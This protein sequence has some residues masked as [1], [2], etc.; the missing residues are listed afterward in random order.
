MEPFNNH[1]FPTKN[2]INQPRT[3][4]IN[5]PIEIKRNMKFLKTILVLSII[6]VFTPFLATSQG[7]IDG[8]VS[9]FGSS[10]TVLCLEEGNPGVVRFRSQPLAMPYAYLVVTDQNLI[11]HIGTSNFIDFTNMPSGIL[12]VISFSFLGPILAEVGDNYL[13]TDL[14][15]LCYQLVSNEI[16]ISNVEP[17]GGDV[18]TADGQTAIAI[19]L[20][21][22]SDN[23]INVV[24]NSDFASYTYI[25]TDE[26]N[27]ILDVSETGAVDFSGAGIGVCHVWGLAYV[28]TLNAPLGADLLD[29]ELAGGCFELS[30]NF[31]EVTRL[32]PDAGSLA[33]GDGSDSFVSCSDLEPSGNLVLTSTHNDATNFTFVMVN[34]EDNRVVALFTDPNIDLAT[35]ISGSYQ[36]YG[37]AYTGTLLIQEGGTFNIDALSDE[38]QDVSG[39][40]VLIKRVQ[41]ADNINLEDGS[42]DVTVCVGDGE[43]DEL[44]FVSTY[45]GN[46]DFV[47]LITDESNFLIGISESATI[48]FDTAEPGVC[49][50]WGLVYSGNLT[51]NVGDNIG[52]P[53]LLSDECF[54]LSDG[55]VRVD[56]NGPVAGLISYED[57]SDS[58]IS[59]TE[60][61][62]TTSLNVNVVGNDPNSDY[63]F[64]VVHS[65][66]IV[67]LITEDAIDLAILPDGTYSVFGVSYIGDLGLEPGDMFLISSITATCFDITTTPLELVKRVQHADDVTLEDGS[68]SAT[69]CV[70]DGIADELTFVSNYVGND[71]FVYLITDESNFLIGTSET[72]VID[73]EGAEAGICRIWGLVYSGDLTVA[74]GENIG[75][76]AILSTECFDLSDGFSLVDRNGPQAGSI[77][78]ADGSNSFF[79]C[80]ETL[81]TGTLTINVTG[82]DGSSDYTFV[83]VD[84]TNTIVSLNDGSIDIADLENGNY[85]IYGIAF[86]GDLGMMVGDTFDPNTSAACLVITT[87]SLQLVRRVQ[88]AGGVTLEDGSNEATVCIADGVSDELT[89]L[90]DFDGEDEFIFIITDE[91]NLVIGTSTTGV[92]EFE[93]ADPGVCHLWGLAYSGNL[94]FENGDD[95]TTGQALSDECYDL[96]DGFVT[97]NRLHPDGGTISLTNGDNSYFECNASESNVILEFVTENVEP[98]LDY[99]F[100]V[101]NTTTN[102]IVAI[103]NA[104]ILDLNSLGFGSFKVHGISYLGNLTI[105]VGDLFEGQPLSD[106]CSDLSDN[107]VNITNRAINVDHIQIVGGATSTTICPADGNPDIIFFESDY[108]GSENLVYIVTD[109]DNVVINVLAAPSDDFDTGGEGVVRVWAVTFS[110]NFILTAGNTLNE[111]LIISDECFDISDNFVLIGRN[112]PE[113]GSVALENGAT[114]IDICVGDGIAD[115]LSVSTTGLGTSYAYLITDENNNI[116]EISEDAV[117]DFENAAGGVC[118]IWVVSYTGELIAMQGDNVETTLLVTGCSELS[119]NFITVNRT[120][121]D[122]GT[123]SLEDGSIS[124]FA[125]GGDGEADFFVFS[126]EN[127]AADINYGYIITDDEE[128]VLAFLEGNS[129]DL[130]LAAAGECHV[131]GVSYTG[132]FLAAVGENINEVS[133]SEGCAEL[134][135]NFV[136]IQ[137]EQVLGGAISLSDGNTFVNI[138]P[139]D[140]NPDILSFI[141]T[142]NSTSNYTYILTD[143]NNNILSTL[144]DEFDFNNIIAPSEVRIWGLAYSGLLSELVGD[145]HEIELSNRCYNVS[146]NFIT[147]VREVPEAGTITGNGLVD[148][149]LCNDD[150]IEDL[151]TFEASGASN[152]SYAYVIAA[153]DNT[154]FAIISNTNSFQFEGLEDDLFRIWGVAYTGTLNDILF[155]DIEDVVLSNDC[156]DLSDNFITIITGELN[157]GNIETNLGTTEQFTCPGDGMA[158]IV[159]VINHNPGSTDDYAFALV[160]EDSLIV[161]LIPSG[162]IDFEAQAEGVYQIWGFIY[163]GDLLDNI[164]DSNIVRVTLSTGCFDLSDNF[165]TVTNIA[166]VAGTISVAGVTEVAVCIGDGIPDVLEFNV[167]GASGAA[168]AYMIIEADSFLVGTLIDPTLDLENSEEG[169]WRICGISY[170]GSLNALPGTNI[171]TDPLSSGCWELTTDCIF[172]DKTHVDGGEVF[173]DL[174]NQ[175]VYSCPNGASDLI[176][177]FNTGSSTEADYVYVLTTQS[178]ILLSVLTDDNIDLLDA[179]GFSNLRLWGVSYTG[180]FLGAIGNNITEVALSDG[181]FSLSSSSVDVFIDNP[182]GGVL[183]LPNGETSTTLCHSNSMPGVVT[184][185]TSSSDAGYAY[186]LTN[187]VNELIEFNLSSDGFVTFDN[188]APG[189]YRV[190]GLSYTGD[191]LLGAGSDIMAGDLATSCFELSENF[192]TIVRTESMDAGNIFTANSTSDILYLCPGDENPDLVI[193]SN[194]SDEASFRYLITDGNDD[195]FVADVEGNI[196]DFNVAPV[197]IYHIYG[198]AFD[199]DFEVDFMENVLTGTLSSQ[200]WALTNNFITIINQ[201]P[202]GGMVSIEGGATEINLTVG[203]GIA[204]EVTFVHTGLQE[205]LYSYIVTDEENVIIAISSSATIDFEAASPGTCR[206]WGVAYTGNILAMMGEDIDEISLGDDCNDLSDNFVTVVRTSTEDLE[207]DDEQWLAGLEMPQIQL[208]LSPN[209]VSNLLSIDISVPGSGA[210]DNQVLEVYNMNGLLVSSA[211]L[212]PITGEQ[213]SILDVS[214]LENGMYLLRWFDGEHVIITRFVKQ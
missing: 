116:L 203:D 200:C 114:S 209:P 142:G 158:D 177:L 121:V 117:I 87:E 27:I 52:E 43:P 54:D 50:V 187:E 124:S 58:F 32:F 190:W 37:L 108:S 71:Q 106:V 123:V 4:A 140:E 120:F 111:D 79:S 189:S 1:N 165:V 56:R 96:T 47:Y 110:G 192:V 16:V 188:V 26:N 5:F 175:V 2:N 115:V 62:P 34:S 156:Y 201:S 150:G 68:T 24:T 74:I 65:N 118:H 10:E 97:I 198:I 82:S 138:C 39:P 146:E 45:I 172:V 3:V 155:E 7:C 12:R 160:N 36:I 83:V 207:G 55:F 145:I 38:C 166:P 99:R 22:A 91:N 191:L 94:L 51:L 204:D 19:C 194:D 104:P 193:L 208:V 180:T 35:L 29:L 84:E 53:S 212:A 214:N 49:R 133:L 30:N 100:L 179:A 33:Y 136:T 182:E 151:V 126:H 143:V 9:I 125:C 88:Q 202:D 173:T 210:T 66:I 28:G 164:I 168:Y 163:T 75:E 199:G 78:F 185:S 122:G 147:V 17:V 13:E 8:T 109:E 48:D 152:T 6:W 98:N 196:I 148:L 73:F 101:V 64:V 60:L 162:E 20:N 197:G 77:A 63:V 57:G 107:T 211:T 153:I 184:V 95:I 206:V 81:P 42:D 170:T 127:T 154:V 72:G 102:E 40:V 105:I 159:T 15:F 25:I 135:S 103:L 23:T 85:T 90:S 171:F 112:G 46:D 113:G 169:D 18:S 205:A 21:T 183:S 119:D 89:F 139:D 69:V 137:R 128:F 181:C 76:P 213:S 131:W 141:N 130:E 70:G 186:L 86:I 149:F 61:D 59:C 134:S 157:G 176:T 129:V 161:S 67:E 31:V 195:V 44:T 174:G 14:A 80:T 167:E 92:V 41:H 132:D 93:F 144:P 178:N 11:V